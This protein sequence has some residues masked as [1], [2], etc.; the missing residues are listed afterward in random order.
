MADIIQVQPQ[1]NVPWLGIGATGN[2]TDYNEALVAGGLDFNV[3]DE[4][5]CWW[6]PSRP[7]D[8]VVANPGWSGYTSQTEDVEMITTV[9]GDTNQVLGLVTPR[10]RIVQNRD[11]FKIMEQVVAVGGTITNAG[12]TQQ[13]L[14][15]MVAN[16]MQ[17][18]VNGEDYCMY[19]MAT[20]SFNGAFPIGLIVTPVRIICQNMYRQ[21][22]GNKDN[23][24][25][26]RHET[27]VMDKLDRQYNVAGALVD[28]N[29]CFSAQV[30]KLAE[31][32]MTV[33]QYTNLLHMLFPYPAPGGAR[34]QTSIMKIDA[35]REE[36]TDVY[37]DAPDN[38]KWKDCAFGFVNAYYDYLSH[39]GNTK[40]MRGSWEDRR[41]TKLVSGDAV[42]SNVIREAVKLCR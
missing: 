15:F 12:M 13:G 38:V 42:K 2:W 9:R 8:E 11:A 25:R 37:F 20:N 7:L 6:K 27:N 18:T 32:K 14:C 17:R 41:L 22:M 23:V 19:I 10:Y 36:F 21:L 26:M 16:V 39:A 24:V 30:L 5:L 1:R 28:Y 29:D 34:E 35:L 4:Q 40:N 3:Y 33:D 31:A